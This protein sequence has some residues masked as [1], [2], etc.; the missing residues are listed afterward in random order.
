MKKYHRLACRVCCALTASCLLT[1]QPVLADTPIKPDSGQVLRDVQQKERTLPQRLEV[2]IIV[3]EAE[4]PPLQDNGLRVYV[5]RFTI[6]G[7]D[8]FPTAVLQPLVSP[9]TQKELTLAGLQKAADTLKTYFRSHGYPLAKAYIPAQDIH[10]GEVELII[11]IG[12]FGEVNLRNSSTV[13]DAVIRR[14]MTAMR[15]GDYVTQG[16]LERPVLL[17]N[18]LPGLNAKMTIT[19]GKTPGTTDIIMDVKDDNN[20]KNSTLTLNNWGNRFTGTW[21]AG[22]STSFSNL[23]KHSGAVFLSLTNA[24]K[25]MTSGNLSYQIPMLEGGKLNISYSQIR[26]ELGEEFASLQSYGTAYTTHADFSYALLRSRK[27]NLSLQLGYDSKRLEDRQDSSEPDTVVNKHSRAY[28]FGM[29]GDSRDNWGGGG[30]TAYSLTHYQGH[31]S[32]S[33]NGPDLN[34]GNWHKTAYSLMRQQFVAERLALLISFNGQLAG[35]NLDS[36]EKFSLGGAT[37]VRAY[38]S[39]EASGDE[40]W[41]CSGELRWQVPGLVGKGAMQLGLFYDTGTSHKAKYPQSLSD[42]SSNRRSI[43]AYGV[44]LM[45]TVPG[46]Y[47]L[48]MT[49]ARKAGSEAAKSDTDRTGR[50]WVQMGYFF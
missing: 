25:G 1:V 16:N 29:S 30:T 19:A 21:Q 47:F 8:V 6:T 50:F 11:V 14:Q 3:S 35:T 17:L 5:E 28:S 44:N 24:G 48:K 23:S 36:S 46:E 20:S 7:Q 40:A 22:L 15:P 34:A 39:G 27:H 2:P 26:Y 41:L 42:E 9:Y 12:R 4:T 49:Y 18:D 31:L 32:G 37:G 33:S 43:S 10:N 38:P 45:Y 13:K